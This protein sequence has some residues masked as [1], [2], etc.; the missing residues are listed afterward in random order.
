MSTHGRQILSTLTDDGKLTVE[1]AD[2][3]LPDPTGV[4]V[5]IEVEGAPINPSD[6]ALLFGPGDTSQAEFTPG[7]IVFPM[8]EAA[9]RAMAGRVGQAMPVGNECAGTVIAAGDAEAAQKLIGQRVACVPGNAFATHVITDARMCMPLPGSFTAEQGAGSFVNPL[10]ALGFV[11]TMRRDGFTGIVHTAA[12]SNLGQM[13]VNL[14]HEERIPLV[15]IVRKQEQVDLLK[16]LG[17]T[18]V[19][20]TSQPGFIEALA[21]ALAET[22]VRLGFDAIGGGK[23]AGQILTAMEMAASKGRTYSRYGSTDAKKVFIYGALDLG[24][25]VL[26]RS[27]GLTWELSGWLLTP[28]LAH[29][30]Q[31]NIDRMRE[32]VVN[33]LT[34]TF[35]SHYKAK[36]SLDG[37]LERANAAAY[38]AKSTGEKYLLVP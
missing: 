24:P 28:F 19:L 36:I 38:N 31:Q 2:M 32:R 35:A 29:A 8:P 1:L 16:N 5:L 21:A 33:G 30:G 23:L 11:E 10:T 7:K 14:C 37:M 17:A 12:A 15:N 3:T 6:L 27:F 9:M 13:L 22:G 26:N 18:H 34:H 20:D 4:Q 25:T